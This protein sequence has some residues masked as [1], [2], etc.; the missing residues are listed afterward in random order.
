[1][2]PSNANNRNGLMVE[3]VVLADRVHRKELTALPQTPQLGIRGQGSKGR[4]GTKWGRKERSS[5]Y[6]E[7]LDPPHSHWS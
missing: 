3:L 4:E 5:S 6:H 1:M 2:D 7:F